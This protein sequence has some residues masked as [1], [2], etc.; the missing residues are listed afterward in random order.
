MPLTEGDEHRCRG[1]RRPPAPAAGGRVISKVIE[2][3]R[4]ARNLG[5]RGGQNLLVG[6]CPKRLLENTM[7]LPRRDVLHLAAGAAAFPTYPASRGRK[8]SDGTKRCYR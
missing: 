3:S 7:K 1:L 2:R 8:C 6:W 4:N 5:P